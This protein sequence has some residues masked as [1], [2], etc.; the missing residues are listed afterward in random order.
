MRTPKINDFCQVTYDGRLSNAIVIEVDS[1]KKMFTAQ[2]SYKAKMY[3]IPFEKFI[4]MPDL[5]GII[6][7]MLNEKYS[8]NLYTVDSMAMNSDIN[9][10]LE[11]KKWMLGL[12]ENVLGD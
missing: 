11:E 12:C 3:D 1:D 2:T 5:G 6:I 10:I 4:P 7:N 8:L 9:D